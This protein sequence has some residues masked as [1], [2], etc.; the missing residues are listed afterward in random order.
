MKTHGRQF[1]LTL[2]FF[3]GLLVCP[4]ISHAQESNFT[5]A[6]LAYIVQSGDTLV[7]IARQF[8]VTV[9][10]LIQANGLKS[11]KILIGQKLNIP[12]ADETAIL[13]N[14]TSTAA[15]SPQAVPAAL[16]L[17]DPELQSL[18]ETTLTNWNSGRTNAVDIASYVQGFEDLRA[19][20]Q[21]EKTEAVA[22]I[23][24]AEE[25]FFFDALGD[26]DTGLKLLHQLAADYPDTKLGRDIGQ[27]L[28]RN[29]TD[30]DL[31]PVS[32]AGN[33]WTMPTHGGFALSLIR[34]FVLSN[35]CV[36]G[37]FSGAEQTNLVI[38]VPDLNRTNKN[39]GVFP[40]DVPYRDGVARISR[41]GTRLLT[42]VNPV[43]FQL[44][45]PYT[46]EPVG[47]S[48]KHMVRVSMAEFSPDSRLLATAAGGVV[49]LWNARDGCPAGD[50]IVSK[51]A[52]VI[53]F[54]SGD[55][56]RLCVVASN[57]V[58][59]VWDVRTGRQVGKPF[60]CANEEWVEAHNSS[61]EWTVFSPD[62]RILLDGIGPYWLW[63]VETGMRSSHAIDQ[64]D[65]IF[66]IKFSPDSK[67]VVTTAGAGER[68]AQVWDAQTGQPLT[69]PLRHR[70]SVFT[71]EFLPDGRR[72]VTTSLDGD[73][74]IWDS[75]TGKLLVLCVHPDAEVPIAAISPDGLHLVTLGGNTARVWSTATGELLAKRLEFPSEVTEARFSA[76][77]KALV[78]V[79]DARVVQIWNIVK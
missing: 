31:T 77:S 21:G 32:L 63:N 79:T 8:G 25:N 13:T 69:K 57:S 12:P 51:Q 53:F 7:K 36:L 28:K 75:I 18:V 58:V 44:L 64:E 19:T 26:G 42:L 4:A 30:D 66:D 10:A 1:I 47:A 67:R 3:A 70:H 76:D 5:K 54:F 40:S 68:A 43:T 16:K 78:T 29:A 34:S 38:A 39:T 41:D 22:Q 6:D 15:D 65:K 48:L 17:I 60:Q 72:F 35:D 62:G 37:P 23:V 9:N 24:F 46:R 2:A 73:A 14:K 20:H 52:V 61:G 45:D 27:T 74:R 50:P 71:A 59:T 56:S 11:I 33:P 49:Q 55:S